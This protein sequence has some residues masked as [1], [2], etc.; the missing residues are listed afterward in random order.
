MTAKRLTRTMLAT[1]VVALGAVAG[2][3]PARANNQPPKPP[4]H[5]EHPPHPLMP[6]IPAKYGGEIPPGQGNVYAGGT[7][8]HLKP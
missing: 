2:V 7:R 4:G 8:R 1:G 3:V 5:P 6:V